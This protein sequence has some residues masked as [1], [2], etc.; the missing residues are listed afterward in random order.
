MYLNYCSFQEYSIHVSGFGIDILSSDLEN[1]KY[2][3]L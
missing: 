1:K 3:R 2:E